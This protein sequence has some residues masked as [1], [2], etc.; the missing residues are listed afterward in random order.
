MEAQRNK[1]M[2]HIKETLDV[3]SEAECA[4]HAALY[5]HGPIDFYFYE[6]FKCYIGDLA[7]VGSEGS[8]TD[9][10]TLRIRQTNTKFHVDS[11]YNLIFGLPGNIWSRYVIED[12]ISLDA[13][14]TSENLYKDCAVRCDLHADKC[15]FFMYRTN[16]PYDCYL[17]TSAS[18]DDG[19]IVTLDDEFNSYHKESDSTSYVDGKFWT[20]TDNPRNW[21]KFIYSKTS[22]THKNRCAFF[23]IYD[24]Q[25]DF[26]V[27][28][29]SHCWFGNMTTTNGHSIVNNQDAQTIYF[30]TDQSKD[31]GVIANEFNEWTGNLNN[32]NALMSNAYWEY[33]IYATYHDTIEAN[34][35]RRCITSYRHTC[36]FYTFLHDHCQ[37][38]RYN[39]DG[40]QIHGGTT[41]NTVYKYRTDYCMYSILKIIGSFKLT[42]TNF[43]AV[44][45]MIQ[46]FKGSTNGDCAN[47][48]YRY[49]TSSYQS[50]Y[51]DCDSW[52][53]YRNSK[54]CHWRFYAPNAKRVTIDIREF[55]SYDSSDSLRIYIGPTTSSYRIAWLYGRDVASS[56]VYSNIPSR[57]VSMY[58]YANHENNKRGFKGYITFSS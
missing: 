44:E 28:W 20:W 23:C 41:A 6:E 4:A 35:A 45:S 13:F 14:T 11:K 34:C 3:V 48:G 32:A 46:D 10:T 50:Y 18:E 42:K 7:Y 27:F 22:S 54:Y 15:D 58:W 8:E 38:G 26:Y 25:C 37:L 47:S 31:G 19:S 17:A 55:E 24:D 5:M 1:W 2:R 40:R 36:M 52:K 33:N 39:Y 49:T 29:N 21:A 16:D 9:L 43:S 30:R 57:V 12:M 51:V 53:W 56:V